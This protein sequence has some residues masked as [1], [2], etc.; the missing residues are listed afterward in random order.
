MKRR[1]FITGAAAGLGV[2]LG[3]RGGD[4]FRF[5]LALAAVLSMAFFFGVAAF[6]N[7]WF[8]I[9]GM[10]LIALAQRYTARD[11]LESDEVSTGAE[12]QLSGRDSK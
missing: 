8:L 2:W 9:A 3:R 5:T 1:G 10:V 6:R 11:Y 7:Y 4:G 12:P